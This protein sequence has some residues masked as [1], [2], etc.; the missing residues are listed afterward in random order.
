MKTFVVENKCFFIQNQIKFVENEIKSKYDVA[1]LN[2][3]IEFLQNVI[4]Q[5]KDVK[6][7]VADYNQELEKNNFPS[8]LK[9]LKKIEEKNKRITDILKKYQN[10]KIIFLE[11]F[12]SS[13]N[14]WIQNEKNLKGKKQENYITSFFDCLDEHFKSNNLPLSGHKPKLNSKNFY[15]YVVEW[16]LKINIFY[17]GD[18]E[19]FQ[20][21]D[22][23]NLFE[24][25]S[26]LKKFYNDFSKFNYNDE[27]K[28]IYQSYEQCVKKNDQNLGEW[29]SINNI[30][31]LYVEEKEKIQNKLPY[32][33]RVFFS[34]LISSLLDKEIV[35]E[36]K[37]LGK[38]TATHSAAVKKDEH[39]W[40]PKSST[41]LQGDN[42]MYLKF[43]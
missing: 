39:L 13:I 3:S 43:E 23:W 37:R 22:S 5:V 7:V 16:K 12:S 38:R 2:I 11:N 19:K 1:E 29:V 10:Y 42:V 4:K 36:G 30:M 28:I 27:L 8:T 21:I 15:F 20:S 17:G 41:D 31:K 26:I 33:E 6:N 25:T 40:L 32:P 34:F 14:S 24:L 9:F 18:E 35:F